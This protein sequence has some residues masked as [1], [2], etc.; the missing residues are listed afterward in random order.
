[1]E[2]NYNVLCSIKINVVLCFNLTILHPFLSDHSAPLRPL[3]AKVSS[4]TVSHVSSSQQQQQQTVNQPPQTLPKP[5]T[6][7]PL[8]SQPKPLSIIQPQPFSQH[9]QP[10]PTYPK[11]FSQS[12]QTQPKPQ[13]FV[14]PLPKPYPQTAPQP[15]PK[16]QVPPQTPPKPQSF[17]KALVK[18]QSLPLDNSEDFSRDSVQSGDLLSPTDSGDLLSDSMSSKQM[19]IRERWVVTEA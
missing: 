9:S 17:P 1:M 5:F 15:P 19:S 6:Q 4:R 11:P 12:P 3:V 14:Q 10:P 7:P 13:G 8:V 18:S 16:P 2:A